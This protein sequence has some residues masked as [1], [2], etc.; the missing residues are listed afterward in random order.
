MNIN[1]IYFLQYFTI[2]PDQQYNILAQT[3]EGRLPSAL[4]LAEGDGKM[5]TYSDLFTFVIMLCA[6]ITLARDGRHKK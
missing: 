3:A 4:S 5:V 2:Q 1:M 6:I